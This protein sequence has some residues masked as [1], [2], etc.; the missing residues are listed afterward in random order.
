MNA[1]VAIDW[2]ENTKNNLIFSFNLLDTQLESLFMNND[3]MNNVRADRLL[4]A[5]QHRVLTLLLPPS[6]FSP[7]PLLLTTPARPPPPAYWNP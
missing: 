2:Q 4:H 3:S 6:P 7:N 5:D 1:N